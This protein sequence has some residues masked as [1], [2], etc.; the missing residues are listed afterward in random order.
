MTNLDILNL[1]ISFKNIKT[2]C[3]IR[4]RHEKRCQSLVMVTVTFQK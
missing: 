4:F 3:P 2:V 1:V